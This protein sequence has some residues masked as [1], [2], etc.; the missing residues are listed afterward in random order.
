MRCRQSVLF[1][2]L[3]G[4]K[5]YQ[6]IWFNRI[7]GI[8]ENF[9]VDEDVYCSEDL[10]VHDSEYIPSQNYVDG[11][12]AVASSLIQ[13][14]SVLKGEL[15]Y[16]VNS[17]LPLTDKI[18]S[19]GIIDAYVSSTILEHPDVKQI[20]SFTSNVKNHQYECTFTVL[21]TFGDLIVSV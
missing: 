3:D 10:L 16:S 21:T 20:K 4:Q 8:S 18:V 15:W 14:L 1:T 9:A 5:H 17:G 11:Q 12:S 13:R 19:K 7:I 6:I 2:G